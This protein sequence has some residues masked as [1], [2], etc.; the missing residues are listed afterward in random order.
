MVEVLV[1]RCFPPDSELIQTVTRTQ[2]D[3]MHDCVKASDH[4][5]VQAQNAIRDKWRC[6]KC[7]SNTFCFIQKHP[8]SF[9]SDVHVELTPRFIDLWA[10]AIKRGH[11]T[12]R[13][14]PRDIEEIDMA[15]NAAILRPAT[16]GRL[17]ESSAARTQSQGYAAP[18]INY[19]IQPPT[20]YLAHPTTPPPQPRYQ[21]ISPIPGYTPKDYTHDA[22]KA[23]MGYLKDKYDEPRFV[24]EIFDKLQANDIGVDLLKGE[25]IEA[26]LQDKC[27]LTI[28]FA[29][30]IVTEYPEWKQ[31]LKDVRS[32]YILI[33]QC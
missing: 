22:L 10:G 13:Q 26:K 25:N 27:G 17:V 6:T 19:N 32:I 21:A 7:S 4:P 15:C 31:S 9:K 3:E 30:R 28:G 16:R 2:L 5:Y 8:D 23:F 11:A 24:C 18:I 12:V 20:P 1:D 29:S 33:L 14:P